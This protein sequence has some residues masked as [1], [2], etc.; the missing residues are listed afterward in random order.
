[1]TKQAPTFRSYRLSDA[2]GYLEHIFMYDGEE[3]KLAAVIYNLFDNEEQYSYSHCFASRFPKPDG[4][5]TVADAKHFLFLE[6]EWYLKQ[7]I[8]P[9]TVTTLVERNLLMAAAN[10]HS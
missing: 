6:I 1:M 5:R 3:S 9:P 7:P 10:S 4:Y 8:E 2:A